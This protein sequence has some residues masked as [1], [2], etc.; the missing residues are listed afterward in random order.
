MSRPHRIGHIAVTGN[1][2]V[3]GLTNPEV[4][5]TLCELLD[6]IESGC[7]VRLASTVT[8][9]EARAYWEAMA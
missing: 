9:I 6:A 8:R 2:W 4:R 3:D 1:D 5:E 7:A